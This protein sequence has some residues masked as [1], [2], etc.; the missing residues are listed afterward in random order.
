MPE[1]SGHFYAATSV[2]MADFRL[3]R[4]EGL[5]WFRASDTASRG[6]C[7]LCGSSLFPE[8]T[9]PEPAVA[10]HSETNLLNRLCPPSFVFS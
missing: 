2:A 3:V 9:R 8:T 6:F 5:R 7:A 4:D 10:S 1:W